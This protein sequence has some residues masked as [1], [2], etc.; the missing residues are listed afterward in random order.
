MGGVN[1]K[2]KGE[3]LYD[4]IKV[5]VGDSPCEVYVAKGHE[6]RCRT[7]PATKTHRVDNQGSHKSWLL[8]HNII[9][10]LVFVK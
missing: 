1:L 4:D 6:A 9:Y 8:R 2:I 5:K 10:Y 7:T 3:G